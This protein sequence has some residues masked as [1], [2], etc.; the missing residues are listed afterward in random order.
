MKKKKMCKM[1]LCVSI[2]YTSLF[3]F[4]HKYK[5]RKGQYLGYKHKTESKE[6]FIIIY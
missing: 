1:L 5:E 4:S 2:I 6:N 3:F